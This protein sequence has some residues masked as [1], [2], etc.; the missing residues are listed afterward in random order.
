[1]KKILLLATCCLGI[2]CLTRV[3]VSAQSYSFYNDVGDEHYNAAT[4]SLVNA[5]TEVY[6]RIDFNDRY[7]GYDVDYYRFTAPVT[8]R[9]TIYTTGSLDT[10]G[11][12]DYESGRTKR[13]S[14]RGGSGDNFKFSLNLDENETYYCYVSDDWS[15]ETGS[16]TLHIDSPLLSLSVPKL[17]SRENILVGDTPDADNGFRINYNG[18]YSPNDKYYYFDGDEKN[19]QVK[20]CFGMAAV[21]SLNYY[22]LLPTTG[23]CLR[24]NFSYNL[25]GINIFN[26]NS[27]YSS[28]SQSEYNLSNLGGHFNPITV[29]RGDSKVN[30]IGQAVGW[31][32][33]NQDSLRL[34]NIEKNSCCIS[35]NN[36][37]LSGRITT[38]SELRSWLWKGEPL[39][40]LLRGS[41]EHAVVPICLYDIANSNDYLMGI[42]DP[43]YPEETTYIKFMTDGY[44]NITNYCHLKNS[45][46]GNGSYDYMEIISLK[47]VASN[48]SALK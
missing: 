16:Y 13:S 12:I 15:G 3:N 39:V 33:C 31:F 2:I 38:Y 6:S 46:Y 44:G 19:K 28:T 18:F 35:I 25:E 1:M 10:S 29:T 20:V 7:S 23:P 26:N 5:S 48:F 34:Y 17:G 30:R 41:V 47:D 24:D 45:I 4:I 11:G 27:L 42:Y 9:Y 22:G 36:A 14:S 32:F 8:G 21:A 43:N 40:V 37:D